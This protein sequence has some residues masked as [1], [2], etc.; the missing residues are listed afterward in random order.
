MA[1]MLAIAAAYAGYFS[2][3]F[4][5]LPAGRDIV[6]YTMSIVPGGDV[7]RPLMAPASLKAQDF[8]WGV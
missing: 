6:S 1:G 5:L 8:M 4:I 3:G 2:S 7:T